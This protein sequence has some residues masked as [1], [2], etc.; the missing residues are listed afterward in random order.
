M[1]VTG[2]VL[3]LLNVLLDASVAAVLRERAASLLQTLVSDAK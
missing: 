1:K 3:L 2:G